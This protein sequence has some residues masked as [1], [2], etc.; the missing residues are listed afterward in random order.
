MGGQCYNQGGKPTT[1]KVYLPLVGVSKPQPRVY[2]QACPGSIVCAPATPTPFPTPPWAGPYAGATLTPTR[3]PA[4]QAFIGPAPRPTATNTPVGL[5]SP[6]WTDIYYSTAKTILHDAPEELAHGSFI[7]ATFRATGRTAAHVSYIAEG[8]GLA[9]SV[10]PNL[11]Y[12]V[13]NGDP[14]SE[15][16]TDL[17]IDV[18]GWAG[19]WVSG[20]ATGGLVAGVTLLIAPP[21]APVAF[22][23]GDVGGSFGGSL[24]WDMSYAPRIR[25][26]VQDWVN[27]MLGE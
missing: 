8:I 13:L 21:I 1:H 16:A 7:A 22:V 26:S 25:P 14:T 17:I 5:G 27:Q 3:T 6:N 12:H 18:G 9:A 23:I 2:K 20:K 24:Y 10:G 4:P 15:I 11:G 19:S